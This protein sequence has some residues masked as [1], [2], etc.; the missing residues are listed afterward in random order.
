MA[1]SWKKLYAAHGLTE[2]ERVVVAP[3]VRAMEA[4]ERAE[5]ENI[6]FVF[7]GSDLD[8]DL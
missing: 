3:R 1:N 7:C 8:V 2:T 6:L 4:M 5:R